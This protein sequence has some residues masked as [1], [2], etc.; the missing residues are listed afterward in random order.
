M[1][2]GAMSSSPV[3]SSTNAGSPDMGGAACSPAGEPGVGCAAASPTKPGAVVVDGDGDIV[4]PTTSRPAAAAKSAQAVASPDEAPEK[5][6]VSGE[7]RREQ[8]K[9]KNGR[10]EAAARPDR[11]SL[12]LRTRVCYTTLV[13]TILALARSPH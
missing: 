12:Y 3:I 11:L 5:A 9:S 4:G 1:T 10:A 7:R 2:G 13:A 8:G 6:M